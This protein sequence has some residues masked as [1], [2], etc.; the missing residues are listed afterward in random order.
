[1]TTILC[2]EGDPT[3]WYIQGNSPTLSE[4][5]GSGK[6]LAVP[7]IH[8]VQ[9]TLLLSASAFGS[10]ALIDP[11]GEEGMPSDIHV[12]AAQVY[13]PTVA[14]ITVTHSG[15]RLSENPAEAGN[16]ISN[17]MK[18]GE[19]ISIAVSTGQVFLNGARVPFV[20][21]CEPRS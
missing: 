1:M 16:R 19:V 3:Q 11:P 6:V 13:V 14:G 7:V 9:G 5:T 10:F 18:T 8:P 17:A 20:V 4:L 15:Y 12:P 2:L 21:I